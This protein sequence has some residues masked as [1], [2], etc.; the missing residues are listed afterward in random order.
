MRIYEIY[1]SIQGE[2]SSV[3][4]P[5]IFVRTTGCHLRCAYCDTTYAF[6]GGRIMEVDEVLAQVREFG[7]KRVCLTGGEPLLQPRQELQKLFDSWA[8]ERLEVSVETSGSIDIGQFRLHPGQ[9]WILD[10]KGPSSGEAERMHL[11]NL[12]LLRPEDEV[13]FVVG[14]EDEYRWYRALLKEHRLEERTR[15]LFSPVWGRLETSQL[16]DWMLRDRLQARLQLQMH[17]LIWAPDKRG[18]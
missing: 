12:G 13:K 9:R 15:I 6:R 17:K 1:L 4:L 2:T 7:Y 11:S 10:I 16:V 8:E 3:G 18:I 5:T 14:D